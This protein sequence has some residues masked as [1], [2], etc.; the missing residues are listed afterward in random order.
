MRH[1]N[2]K[3]ARGRSGRR[4]GGGGPNINRAY[5]SNG[6]SGK[7]RGTAAQLVE[8]YT[9]LARDARAGRDRVLVENYYQHAEHYQ[10]LVNEFASTQ[11][12]QQPNRDD[13]P[14]F[15]DDD[16]TD[17]DS[18]NVNGASASSAP[19]QE[20]QPTIDGPLP[21]DEADEKPVAPKPRKRRTRTPAA[22]ATAEKAEAAEEAPSADA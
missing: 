17:G 10:R 1:S 20:E 19:G 9:A 5:D 22:E 4:S 21:G 18:E 11:P 13:Q 3:R 7:I 12:A 16:E 8:K 6:P 14:N 15:D 2:G